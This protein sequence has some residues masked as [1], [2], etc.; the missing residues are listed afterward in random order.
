MSAAAI[1]ADTF[2]REAGLSGRVSRELRELVAFRHLVR[3]LVSTSLR[4]ELASTTLGF[5]WWILDPLLLMAVYYIFIGIILN[6]DLV[7][8]YALFVLT[9]IISWEFFANSVQRS[10]SLTLA[11]EG[12]MREVAYPRSAIPLAATLTE[13]IHFAVAVGVLL[14]LLPAFGLAPGPLAV[15]AIPLA[16]L[17]FVF[18][19]GVS[20]VFAAAY[21]F[22]RDLKHLTEHVFWLWFHLSPAVYPAFLFPRQFL[23]V[24]EMNPF[25]TFF[26]DLRDVLM[27]DRLPATSLLHLGV[28]SAA[29]LLVLVVGFVTFVEAGRSFAKVA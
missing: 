23:R 2:G 21:V 15:V 10:M 12:S 7:P 13:T 20:Y 11:K 18:A 19:L 25:A 27:Y 24:F 14:A 22:F 4:A 9:A 16:L 6:R 17:E 8:H 26:E 1:G 28:L 3:H 5:V 29:C